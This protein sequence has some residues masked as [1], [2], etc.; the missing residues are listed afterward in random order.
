MRAAAIVDGKLEIVDRAVPA[1]GP[2]EV[3]IAI[4]RC[5]V[6]GTDLHLP[7]RPEANSLVPGHEVAGVVADL[8]AEAS[9][10]RLGQRVSVLPSARCGICPPC[11]R[12][13]V[14]VCLN[15]WSGALGFG[16]D[17]GYAEYVAVPVTSCYPTL[18]GMSAEHAALVEPY[19]VAIHG[20]SLGAPRPGDEVVIVGA[21]PVGLLSIAAAKA[22]GVES[23]TVVE[24]SARRAQA[25]ADFGATSVLH[26]VS[27]LDDGESSERSVVLE[28]SGAPGMVEQSIR[29]A[30]VGGTVVILGVPSAG[31]I[32]SIKPRGWTR[33]EVTVSPSIWYTLDDFTTARRRIAEEGVTP[34]ML[35]VQ[36]RPLSQ[37]ADV[38][39]EIPT[40]SLVKVQLDPS[41]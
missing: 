19:S 25:A 9:G 31:E 28:C 3:L 27:E 6:C 15:Q 20:V 36:V 1:F 4:E 2:H 41:N 10:L 26:D 29:V 30:R 5:G 35:S 18:N 7:H 23:V 12:G 34:S 22:R 32:I 16:R 13:D 39:A 17:G 38:F 37:V 33:K 40:G 14:Q 21:G 11:R 8:G 24:P